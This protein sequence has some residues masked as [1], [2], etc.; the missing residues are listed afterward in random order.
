MISSKNCAV[1]VPQGVTL[2][3]NFAWDS[4]K[5]IK[6]TLYKIAFKT[7]DNQD[8]WRHNFPF[9]LNYFP[10]THHLKS[11]FKIFYNHHV[12]F[13]III[14]I[15]NKQELGIWTTIIFI[16]LYY[17]YFITFTIVLYLKKANIE[18]RSPPYTPLSPFKA[19]DITENYYIFVVKR[20]VN[21]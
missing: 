13:Y 12:F 18:L 10:Q 14:F 20:S 15:D 17:Y 6:I 7:L 16:S 19:M 2:P 4:L 9:K 5:R 8:N 21:G 11:R 3:E 1:G